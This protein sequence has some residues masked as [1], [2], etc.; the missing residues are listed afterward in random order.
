MPELEAIPVL[1]KPL[2]YG[3]TPSEDAMMRMKIE[4]EIQNDL[5]NKYSGGGRLHKQKKHYYQHGG[6]TIPQFDGDYASPQ[7]PN[8]A[9]Y[10]LNKTL[11]MAKNAGANDCYATNSCG[12]NTQN[13]GY[14]KY[15]RHSKTKTN[16]SLK[17]RK[18]THSKKNRR[19]VKR[20]LKRKNIK[21]KKH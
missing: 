3:N 17:S 18:R 14:R 10:E 12:I 13:G 1:I 5:N 9:S 7:N 11:I 8:S 6:I 15:N 21:H 2:Q 20:T 4:S 19:S 16:K